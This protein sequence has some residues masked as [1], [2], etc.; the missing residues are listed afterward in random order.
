MESN[1]VRQLSLGA[2]SVILI[3][4]GP[5]LLDE[6]LRFG[7]RPRHPP[8]P[9]ISPECETSTDWLVLQNRFL[10]QL[11]RRHQQREE[12]RGFANHSLL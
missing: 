1:N 4:L 8:N 5:T 9:K 7:G 10:A 12:L 2:Y 11:P 3:C 6:R